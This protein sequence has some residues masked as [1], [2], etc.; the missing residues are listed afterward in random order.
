MSVIA[1]VCKR[2][3]AHFSQDYDEPVVVKIASMLNVTLDH[4]R[5][6]GLESYEYLRHV[7]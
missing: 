7:Q 6:S 3:C 2:T 5:A 1:N 4:P